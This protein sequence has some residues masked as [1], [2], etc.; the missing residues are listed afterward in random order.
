MRNDKVKKKNMKITEKTHKKKHD[1][2]TRE[3][4]LVVAF[5]AFCGLLWFSVVF[6][7][8]FSVAFEWLFNGCFVSILSFNS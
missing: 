6:F 8:S 5:L 7:R 3:P 1:K 4:S 2:K